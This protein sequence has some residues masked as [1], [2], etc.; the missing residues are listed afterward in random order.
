MFKST[1]LLTQTQLCLGNCYAGYHP[2]YRFSLMSH[3][4]C[5]CEVLVSVPEFRVKKLA[6]L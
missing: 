5:L 1:K 6:L 2:I 4:Q 3:L